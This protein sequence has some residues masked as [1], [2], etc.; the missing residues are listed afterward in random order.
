MAITL[1][2]CDTGLFSGESTGNWV[3]ELIKT[4]SPLES[5]RTSKTMSEADREFSGTAETTGIL[6]ILGVLPTSKPMPGWKLTAR[7]AGTP[8]PMAELVTTS[9]VTTRF[10][11][12]S[13]GMPA[14]S[15]LPCAGITST[16]AV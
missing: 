13:K 10:T 6:M 14:L 15:P 9:P 12:I 5:R 3:L 8:P 1:P 11:V 7:L 4:G 16:V 2:F